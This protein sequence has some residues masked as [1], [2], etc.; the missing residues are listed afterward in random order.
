MGD[1]V[2]LRMLEAPAGHHPEGE[3]E[4]QHHQRDLQQP[5]GAQAAGGHGQLSAH[6]QKGQFLHVLTSGTLFCLRECITKTN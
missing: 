3:P 2:H 6:I 4:P 5:D 1:S